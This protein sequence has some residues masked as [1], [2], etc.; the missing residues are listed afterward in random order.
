MVS[1]FQISDLQTI[2]YNKNLCELNKRREGSKDMRVEMRAYKRGE[3]QG[4]PEDPRDKAN[5]NFAL[6]R[7]SF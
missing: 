5:T 1:K 4:K 7:F 3:A 6:S 2:F